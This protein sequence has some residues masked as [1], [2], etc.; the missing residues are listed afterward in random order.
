MAGE[1][2]TPD[3][4]PDGALTGSPTGVE[5]VDWHLL[6]LGLVGRVSD[7][8]VARCRDL[9]ADQREAEV[10]QEL[11]APGYPGEVGSLWYAPTS[12]RFTI[13]GCCSGTL[14]ADRSRRVI[15]VAVARQ[16]PGS[17]FRVTVGCVG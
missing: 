12:R 3:Q 10:G 13:G 5:A 7:S 1:D 9:L 8:V 16:R 11:G 15:R 4:R 17:D 2:E 14:S 6:L